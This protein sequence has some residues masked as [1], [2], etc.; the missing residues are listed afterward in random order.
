M[1]GKV[2]CRCCGGLY[3]QPLQRHVHGACQA[4]TIQEHLVHL[5]GGGGKGLGVSPP[6]GARAWGQESFTWGEGAGEGGGGRGLALS[7]NT[8]SPGEG[9]AEPAVQQ[10]RPG[11]VGEAGGGRTGFGRGA[12]QGL[13]GGHCALPRGCGECKAWW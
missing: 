10:S 3:E 8:H 13:V 7:R 4:G 9:G 2:G 1:L 12:G 11:F 5:V 6:T